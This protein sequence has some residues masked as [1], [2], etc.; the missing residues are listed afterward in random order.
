M[1]EKSTLTQSTTHKLPLY[2]FFK[3]VSRHMQLWSRR[4]TATKSSLLTTNA[5]QLLLKSYPEG[6]DSI[7]TF[8]SNGEFHVCNPDEKIVLQVYY[9]ENR[10]SSSPFT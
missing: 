4:L 2:L 9:R 5:E 1:K 10:R 6:A 3:G 7:F 8:G